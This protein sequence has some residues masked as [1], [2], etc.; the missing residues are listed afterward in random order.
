MPSDGGSASHSGMLFANAARP[1]RYSRSRSVHRADLDSPTVSFQN[2]FQR[3][4]LLSNPK[5][6]H[7]GDVPAGDVAV[8]NSSEYDGKR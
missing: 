4:R 6:P 8:G 5:I 1:D 3:S 7:Q 2:D